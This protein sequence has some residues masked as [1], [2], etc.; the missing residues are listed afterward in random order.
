MPVIRDPKP[1]EDK[2]ST[3]KARP[4]KRASNARPAQKRAKK[5]VET[6]ASGSDVGLVTK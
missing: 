4:A 1:V 3:S 6:T 2:R 5:V